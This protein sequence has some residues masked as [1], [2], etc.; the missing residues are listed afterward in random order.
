M[1]Q[2]NQPATETNSQVVMVGVEQNRPMVAKKDE[3]ILSTP[4]SSTMRYHVIGYI[5]FGASNT[6]VYKYQNTTIIDG[7][8]FNHPFIQC[9][10]MFLGMHMPLYWYIYKSKTN[11]LNMEIDPT[12]KSMKQF[13]DYLQ[14]WIPAICD[15]IS[16]TLNFTALNF[17]DSSVYQMLRGGTIIFTS[18]FSKWMFRKKFLAYRYVGIGQVVVGLVIVGMSNFFFFDSEDTHNDSSHKLMAII[19]LLISMVFNGLQYSYE[20]LIYSRYNIHPTKLVGLE[21]L[22][23]L[24]IYAILL[25]IF[26]STDCP[27]PN[28]RGCTEIRTIGSDGLVS[29]TY[30]MESVS[31]FF[32]QIGQDSALLAF[33][34]IGFFTIAFY[35]VN[36]LSTTKF[37]SGL[38]RSIIDQI[39]T[40]F[41]WIV[42]LAVTFTG[43][44]EWET[45][46]YRANILKIFGF[47][48]IVA[49][50]LV[51]NGL[52]KLP[53]L[54]RENDQ[55]RKFKLSADNIESDSFHNQFQAPDLARLSTLQLRQ[56]NSQLL[57]QQP[58]QIQ[59][60]HQQFLQ[61]QMKKMYQ[62]GIQ[63]TSSELKDLNQ[64]QESDQNNKLV[65][66]L[67]NE[68]AQ[69]QQTEQQ[70]PQL[71]EQQL[72]LQQQTQSNQQTIQIQIQS[73][74][75]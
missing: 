19:L 8:A 3:Q 22:Y 72:E 67:S 14:V 31:L 73:S 33:V 64:N 4:I 74:A 43:A 16:S 35:N 51:Y 17:I 47:F 69:Q 1:S 28:N 75:N 40:I 52:I 71:T 26:N 62:T 29:T 11:T 45:L 41:I 48:F 18:I 56:R 36:G 65:K 66:Q 49:G 12:K 6:L 24:I 5:L 15:F 20:E 30:K 58:Q 70:L 59:Q 46:D 7:V 50:N 39:R 44:R 60:I 53:Y 9:I 23:G 38:T 27:F 55:E 13:K 25:P 68:Y 21:G 63:K 37:F 10:I 54:P 2:S 34:I 61:F 32:S 57:S 42:G